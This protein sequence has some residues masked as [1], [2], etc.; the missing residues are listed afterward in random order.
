MLQ[1]KPKGNEMD[2]VSVGGKRDHLVHMSVPI[3][4]GPWRRPRKSGVSAGQK[5]QL[6]CVKFGATA[7]Q[8]LM[9]LYLF[10]LLDPGYPGPRNMHELA[11]M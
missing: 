8:L 9:L 6:D 1:R 5:V 2:C 4:G 11:S 10:M 7:N 3:T